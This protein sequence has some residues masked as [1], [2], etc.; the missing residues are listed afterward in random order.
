M[1]SHSH[2]SHLWHLRHNK[3]QEEVFAYDVMWNRETKVNKEANL[4]NVYGHTPQE[5]EVKITPSYAIVDTGCCFTHIKRYGKLSAYCV[6]SGEVVEV[7]KYKEKEKMNQTKIFSELG[8][9]NAIFYN[10]EIEKG[11]YEHRLPMFIVPKK[12]EGIYFRFWVWKRVFVVSSNNGFSLS[13]KDRVKLKILFGV[14]GR[15]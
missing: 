8:Y 7:K 11:K 10:T 13:R 12:I 2:I 14:E 5:Y 9:G 3:N 15:K 6:E 1:V 4:F